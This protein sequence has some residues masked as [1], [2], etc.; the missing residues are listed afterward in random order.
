GARLDRPEDSG[1]GPERH[2]DVDVAI[3]ADRFEDTG[4]EGAV[5]LEGELVRVDVRE[6]I[7]E[8][9]GVERDRRAVPLD[10]RL[11]P[12]DVVPDL[13]VR[14]DGDRRIAIEPDAELDDVRRLMR[15]QR[16]RPNGSK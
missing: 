10:R 13:G 2:H 6:H 9:P 8:E 3:V 4:R 11:H 12:T 16:R 5:E 7:G 15:Y 14:T 1:R